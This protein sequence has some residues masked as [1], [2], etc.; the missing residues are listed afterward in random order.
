[1]LFRSPCDVGIAGNK[2]TKVAVLA[3]TNTTIFLA[4]L[5][6]NSGSEKHQQT[7]LPFGRR[8]QLVCN[9]LIRI[10]GRLQLCARSMPDQSWDSRCN[11]CQVARGSSFTN[12]EWRRNDSAH[13]GNPKTKRIYL[14]CP[15]LLKNARTNLLFARSRPFLW[16]QGIPRFIQH[17]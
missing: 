2:K 12:L 14:S 17:G 5:A 3:L 1:M 4:S 8:H 10:L 16:P 11:L 7:A 15:S 6:A 9:A 13:G